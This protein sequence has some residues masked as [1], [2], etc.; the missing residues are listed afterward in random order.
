MRRLTTIITDRFVRRDIPP[1]APMPVSAVVK[2]RMNRMFRRRLSDRVLEVLYE[3]CISGD[4]ET[5]S[6]LL[7]VVEAMHARRQ[8]AAGDRRLSDKEIV[9]AREDLASRK[10]ERALAAA[11]D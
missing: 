4:L 10:A 9:E 5:A 8:S 7:Q 1:Q 2:E 3:A 6:E 11:A